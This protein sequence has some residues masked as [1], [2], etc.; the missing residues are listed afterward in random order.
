LGAL[1]TGL[2]VLLFLR[3]ARSALIVVTTIPFA[4]LA[5]VVGLWLAG[6]TIN[7]MTLGGLALA[8][9]V[10]V[11]EATVAV[12]NIH[13]HLSRGSPVR[14]AVWD[15]TRETVTPR[16]LAMLAVLAVFAPSLFMAGVARSLFVP[17]SLA[18][19]FAMLASYFL[20]NTLV[21]NFQSLR[22]A[23]VILSMIPAVVLG[24][25]AAL[26]ASGTT[27]N[28][29]SFMGAIMAVGVSVANAILL[30]A[31][32]EQRRREGREARAAAMVAA[33]SR[34]RPIPM[35]SFAMIAG[36]TPMALGIG[37]GGEQAAPLG[38]A[39]IGGLAA[40]TI[41]VLIVLP[42]VFGIAQRKASRASA[43]LHPDDEV[44]AR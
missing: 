7:I 36:M 32:A 10:L 30:G 39:V 26:W 12:E 17:L 8:I 13:T 29:Q 44:A 34:L 19:G 4:I 15:A 11:D 23:L 2:M 43:S 22:A 35:T 24:V 40:S 37:E 16:L 9:G 21:A 18:V 5:G 27:L 6:Q 41:A 20:S 38:R 25:V 31:F 33:S 42:S 1:L 14:R 3:D 28:M